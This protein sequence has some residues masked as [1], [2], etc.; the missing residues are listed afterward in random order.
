MTNTDLSNHVN[1]LLSTYNGEAYL[2]DQLHSLYQQTYQNIKIHVRD[3]GSS[4]LTLDILQ[5]E[6][7]EDRILLQ[8]SDTNIGP[9]ASFFR[10]LDI[11]G[12]AGYYAFCDQDDIW[13]ANKIEIAVDAIKKNPSETP[14]MYFS[15]LVFVNSENQFIK[16]SPLPKGVAFENA[17]VE[18][19]AT[20]CTIVL[21]R[22]ARDL[23][24]KSIPSQCVMHDAW[25]YLL[26]SCL[27]NVIYDPFPSIHYRQHA[28]NTIG[29]STSVFDT[30]K[31]RVRRF[32]FS[33]DGVFRFSNQA[34]VLFALYR[35]VIPIDKKNKLLK[36]ISAE[37]SLMSRLKLAF[38]DDIWR[39]NSVD[40]LILRL[41]I[42]INRY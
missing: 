11:S 10:L 27:G 4:D 8:S 13:L 22:A 14:V 31:R 24:L 21:N 16:L 32:K 38:S 15:R 7:A 18:N 41:L 40:N 37:Q 36:F 17:L 42:I 33:K 9:A 23:I 26:I 2:H 3:D 1:V 6:V 28:S 25:C 35:N 5:K 12:D 30:I 29:A 20:G 39:Q 34:E 19:I